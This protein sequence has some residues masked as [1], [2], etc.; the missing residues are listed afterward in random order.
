M[1]SNCEGKDQNEAGAVRA[2]NRAFTRE[3]KDLEAPV[4]NE[5]RFDEV[6]PTTAT[7]G[8]STD[9]KK[10]GDSSTLPLRA[11][12]VLLISSIGV[13]L[14]SVSTSALVIAFPVLILKLEITMATMMWILLC[15]LLIIA[16]VVGIAGKLGDILGQATLYK[17]GYITF[18]LGSLGGG[19]CTK[20]HNGK[21]LVAARC[22][23]GFGAAFL[24]T[25]SSAI[26]TNEFSRYGKVGLSQGV[27]QLHSAL[28]MVLGPLIGGAFADTTWQWI[29]F[30]N[31][32]IGGP[33]AL[34]SLWAVQDSKIITPK[35]S[36]KEFSSS[37]D[38]IGAIFYPTGL[39][40]I[41]VA[42][43]QGVVPDPVLS[44][45]GPL[46]GLIVSGCTCGIIFLI[47][48]FYAT[49]PIFPP[50]MFFASKVFSVTVVASTCV[51][52]A[53]YSITYN[54][55]FYLQGPKGMDP[56]E[57]G[58]T[59]IPFGIGIMVAGFAGGLLADKVGVRQMAVFG[60]VIT[61]AAC[62]VFLT[63]DE[64]TTSSTING[65]LFLAGFGIG[66]FNSPNSMSNM[67]SVLPA[68]RGSA[69]AV[70][71]VTMMFTAMVGIVMSFAFILNDMSQMDLFILFIY[72]G[73]A[74]SHQAVQKMLDALN[75]DYYIV[76][77]VLGCASLISILNDFQAK[78]HSEKQKVVVKTFAENDG[79]VNK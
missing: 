47:D 37:F 10:M 73:S 4:A 27:F 67:L 50:K 51:A 71:M 2:Q 75:T 43:L 20:G 5:V 12:I 46:T 44:E 15:V 19:L 38:W 48:Q 64:K 30:F 54:M 34:L 8:A 41:L 61:I 79:Q 36:L 52:F 6:L 62:C 17:F 63:F 66:L 56:L 77:A 35:K 42:M 3:E 45:K 40:L 57:A 76:I 31:L 14:A 59:L 60:P 9:E 26:L 29:F 70:G 32:P 53:R 13:F 78:D 25:N 24:F 68:E 1:N 55:I 22:I 72:G 49:D 23:L 11:W 7:P 16:G 65:L 33:C 21:D 39:V 18:I 28:G 74:L 58:I 69:S